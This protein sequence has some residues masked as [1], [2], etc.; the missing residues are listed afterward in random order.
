MATT[1]MVHVR[2]DEKIK[3]KASKALAA[4]GLSVSDAVR[5]MLVRVAAEKALPFEVKVPNKI[6]VKAMRAADKGKGTRYHSA[7]ALF[8]DLGI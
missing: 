6:T 8:K 3:A 4:M 1:N 5:L 7:T 2:V